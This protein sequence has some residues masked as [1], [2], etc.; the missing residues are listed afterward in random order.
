VKDVIGRFTPEQASLV[1]SGLIGFVTPWVVALV[2]NRRMTDQV[3]IGIAAFIAFT[4]AV[5]QT[6]L[7]GNFSLANAATAFFVIYP[8]SQVI[9]KNVAVK[10]GVRRLEDITSRGAGAD[11][12]G[13]RDPAL[14][15]TST[16][17]AVEAAIKV[18][19]TSPEI[20]VAAASRHYNVDDVERIAKGAEDVDNGQFNK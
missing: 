9:Y 16:V 20:A 18:A 19:E 4:G 8:I 15:T 13:G 5:L 7:M 12:D 2:N 3:R 10:L 14:P 17:E 6:V 1:V 11:G